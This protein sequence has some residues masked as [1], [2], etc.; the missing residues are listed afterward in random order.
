MCALHNEEAFKALDNALRIREVYPLLIVTVVGEPSGDDIALRRVIIERRAQDS[1]AGTQSETEFFV[2]GSDAMLY[3]HV[4]YFGGLY[5][6]ERTNLGL[7]DPDKLLVFVMRR[8]MAQG[9]TL[10]TATVR[11][12]Q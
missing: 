12:V 10:Q 1:V 6:Q 3:H 11:S 9:A 4:A 5:V 7:V 8:S 2:F